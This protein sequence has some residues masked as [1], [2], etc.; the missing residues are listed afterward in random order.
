MA[1]FWKCHV[2]GFAKLSFRL[3]SQESHT[4]AWF[5]LFY[6]SK[7]IFNYRESPFSFVFIY[8]SLLWWERCFFFFLTSL[9]NHYS[10]NRIL[11]EE[12]KKGHNK[13]QCLNKQQKK[14]F[15]IVLLTPDIFSRYFR[16]IMYPAVYSPDCTCPRSHLV[17]VDLLSQTNTHWVQ[18]TFFFPVYLC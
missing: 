12:I 3:L 14:D 2:R 4:A 7:F 1:V 11:E 6:F 15:P 9:P 5:I 8:F 16:L 13:G 17:Q 10:L 18:K